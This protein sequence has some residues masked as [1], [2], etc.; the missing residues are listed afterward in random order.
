M[1]EVSLSDRYVLLLNDVVNENKAVREKL[2]QTSAS[3]TIDQRALKDLANKVDNL[4]AKI[5][6]LAERGRP[7]RQTGG[8][9]IQV[10]KMCSNDVRRKIKI[11]SESL[12]DEVALNINE[13]SESNH[14]LAVCQQLTNELFLEYGGQE[15]CPWTCIQ[16]KAAF[17]TYMKSKKAHAKRTLDG[18]NAAHVKKCRRSN[19][20]REKLGRRLSSL[21]SKDWTPE[22][23]AK[24]AAVLTLDYISSD[25]SDADEE[26]KTV[27]AVKTLPGQSQNLKNKK[28]SLDKHHM[29]SLPALVRRRLYLRKKGGVS[30]RPK[31]TDCPDWACKDD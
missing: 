23:K 2:E 16:I 20:K 11:L 27:Y 26:G 21:N 12:D 19:R 8:A 25:E 31:P 30:L 29:E 1:A 10:P 15:K 7:V 14:N 3:T 5:S 9:R 22:R 4:D 6:K 28:K 18:T 24:V 13:S 17:K